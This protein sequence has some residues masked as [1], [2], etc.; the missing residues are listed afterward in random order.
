M[1]LAETNR[2]EFKERLT[3]D[4]DIEK[5]V[6]AFLNYRE[7]GIL[8]IG[9]DKTGKAV[10]V[11]DIDGDMLKIKDRIRNN[12]SPSPM[13][14]FEVSTEN[15][16]GVD[17]IRVFVA[18]GSEKPYYK[19]SFGMS[20]KGCFVRVGT[21]AE[22][23]LQTMIDHLYAGRVHQSLR[24]VP[25]PRQD[26]TFQQL[27]IY[28]Q[29]R[30]QALGADFAKTLLFLTDDG[31]YNY[32]AYLFADENDVSVKV[33]KYAGKDRDQLTENNEYGYCSLLKS[34]E[35]VVER[36]RIENI[37]ASKKTYPFRIDTPLW[38]GDSIR[39]LVFNAFIHNDFF[40]EVPPKFELFSDHLEITST[41]GLPQ[42]L[43]QEEFFAGVSVPRN[44]EVMRVFRDVR[45]GEGL[46]SGMRLVMKRYTKEVF[47]FL[48]HFLRINVLYCSQQVDAP[49]K[50]TQKT[51]LKTN[52]KTDMKTSMKKSV[53]ELLEAINKDASIS[54]P[55]MAV[56]TGLS[57]SGVRYHLRV[58]REKGII[59]H[60]G[61]DKGGYWLVLHQPKNR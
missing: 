24:N 39:E 48:P 38:D 5:E 7:G 45:M 53:V 49:Q 58:L 1:A 8:Y 18:S 10:G 51:N 32:V 55:Q 21:A 36:L 15:I 44:K 27:Q 16:D 43:S 59:I 37:V 30:N 41:G 3:R 6:V 40:G 56:R 33:A 34:A 26:L 2:I 13:G 20:T 29:N 17:V 57:I 35:A 4:L 14:L 22:P 42:E 47:E 50:T 52:L 9:I 19:T 46:G 11:E 31:R 23:M 25:A 61:P 54:I 28:Y 60:K 12:I